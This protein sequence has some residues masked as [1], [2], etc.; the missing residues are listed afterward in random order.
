MTRPHVLLSV[1]M[2]LDGYIDDGREARFPLSGDE[3]F[4]A[5][6]RL[7]A[8]CD[9]IL[10]G[11]G[12][13]RTDNPRLLVRNAEWRAARV[14][15][16]RPEHPLKVVVS[17]SGDLDP[18]LVFWHCGDRKVL[19]T[20]DSGAA[21]T[22]VRHLAD[23]VS[24]GVDLDYGAVLD[25]LGARGVGRLLVEGGTTVHTGFLVAGLADE[26]RMAVAPLFIGHSDAPRFTHPGEFPGGPG[27]RIE[28]GEVEKLGD[29]VVL[30]YFPKR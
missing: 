10:V 19:Y 17:E 4:A 20:T 12:T 29:V 21:R 26:I 28:C 2:S 1:A 30:R 14:A 16:G 5:V 24:L 7:R 23:V 6:D 9:A 22:P 3:D 11:A 27:R 15:A 13:V 8:E 18:G 25:D